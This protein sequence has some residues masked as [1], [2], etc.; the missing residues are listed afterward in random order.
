MLK[1]ALYQENDI[2]D[3]RQYFESTDTIK[4]NGILCNMLNDLWKALYNIAQY[5]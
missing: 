1:I 3:L 2:S 4:Y 5:C